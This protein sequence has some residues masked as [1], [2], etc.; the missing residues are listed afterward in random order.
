[1]GSLAPPAPRATARAGSGDGAGRATM[2]HLFITQDFGPDLGGMAR[3]QVELCRRFPAGSLVVA[4]VAHP[5]ADSFD[6]GEP[7][8]IERQDFP[9]A[10]AGR[11]ANQLRWARWL[12]ARVRSG[13]VDLLHCGNVR[14]T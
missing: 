3:H 4:T 11:F 2:R 10:R 9:F 14:P 5:L 1:M 13:A 8:P 7:Y 12:T 6:A